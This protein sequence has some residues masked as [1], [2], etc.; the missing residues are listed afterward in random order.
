MLGLVEVGVFAMTFS[1]ACGESVLRALIAGLLVIPISRW[2]C[3]F[4]NQRR[5]CSRNLALVAMLVPFFAPEL[6]IG[7]AYSSFS[8]VPSSF[9]EW[10]KESPYFNDVLYITLMTL[11]VAPAAALARQFAPNPSTSDEAMHCHWMLHRTATSRWRWFCRRW[12][13]RHCAMWCRGPL[14]RSVYPFGIGFLLVFQEFETASLL[15]IPTWTVHLFD[16]QF[17]GLQLGVTLQRVVFPIAIELVVIVCI[18]LAVA[19]RSTSPSLVSN[20]ANTNYAGFGCM[21]LIVSSLLLVVLPC[22]VIGRSGLNG[23]TLFWRNSVM[24]SSFA[25]EL[26]TGLMMAAAAAIA[27]WMLS[28][29]LLRRASSQFLNNR[30]RRRWK[31]AAFV[32]CIPG[33]AGSLAISL[34]VLTVIQIPGV[35]FLRST[36][37][38]SLVAFTLFLLPRA[39]LLSLAFD[40]RKDRQSSDVLAT[41]AANSTSPK[42]PLAV[43]KLSWHSFGKPQFWSFVILFYWCFTNLTVSSI[44]NPPSIVPLPVRLYN[45]MHYGQN[46]PLSVMALLSLGIPIALIAMLAGLLPRIVRRRYLK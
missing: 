42:S 31:V 1:A 27:A 15:A 40:L 20:R 2:Q 19:R 39:V 34:Q 37:I 35:S 14:L 11:K 7:Y 12:F 5:S 10:A 44:L 23:L 4:L 17:Q 13:C 25:K 46:S 24:L 43:A 28:S 36:P 16:A 38:P 6:L 21:S 9:W 26:S 33:L 22:F 18:M 29:F 3:E 30:S 8:L 45:L 32:L 41:M